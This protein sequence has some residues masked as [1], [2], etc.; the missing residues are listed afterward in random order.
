M[1]NRPFRVKGKQRMDKRKSGGFTLIEMMI[2][3]TII[4][5]LAAIA[6]PAF[7]KYVR[8]AKTTEALMN[9]RKLFDGSVVY[10]ERD[11]SDRQGTVLV[12]QFPGVGLNYGPAPGNNPCCGQPADK[13]DADPGAWKHPVWMALNFAVD[14]PHYFWYEYQ[15]A[16]FGQGSGFTARAKGNLNCNTSYST[17]ERV[18][19]VLE[20][21]EVMGGAGIFSVRPLE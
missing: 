19:G 21:G 9:L 17:F 2:V 10:Y 18:G 14:D 3:V 1:K 12:P 7:T 5:V 20:T 4:G 11:H 15:S 13:C 6:I 8:R 16:G